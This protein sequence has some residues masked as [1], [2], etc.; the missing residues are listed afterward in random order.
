MPPARPAW[1]G[2]PP[3]A[4][5]AGAGEGEG[6]GEAA[7]GFATGAVKDV[8]AAAAVPEGCAPEP[9]SLM[10]PKLM[11][12]GL[13]PLGMAPVASEDLLLCCPPLYGVELPFATFLPPFPVGTA[14]CTRPPFTDAVEADRAC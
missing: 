12:T 1:G 13:E 14:G 9:G 5:D 4:T 10:A 2:A 7:L 6:W 8:P 11:F 3:L